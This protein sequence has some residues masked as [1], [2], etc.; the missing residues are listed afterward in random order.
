M[1]SNGKGF[2]LHDR[3]LKPDLLW[4]FEPKN[5]VKKNSLTGWLYKKCYFI[6]LRG[7]K[8]GQERASIGH[9]EIFSISSGERQRKSRGP[10]KKQERYKRY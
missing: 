9:L 3:F 6:R 10:Q 1:P 7:T 4:S 8:E 5:L 2:T